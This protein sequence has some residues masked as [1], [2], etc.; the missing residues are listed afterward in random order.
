MR[1]CSNITIE[2]VALNRV[3]KLRISSE[4]GYVI[5]EFF[6]LKKLGW[7]IIEVYNWPQNRLQWNRGSEGPAVH[8]EQ[9][10]TQV[11]PGEGVAATLSVTDIRPK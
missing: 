6:V 3:L 1:V 9:E 7:P 2:E 10:L 8:T 11:P 4:T 5:W